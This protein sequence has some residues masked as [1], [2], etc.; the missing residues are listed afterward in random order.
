MERGLPG[1]TVAIGG[2]GWAENSPFGKFTSHR[3]DLSFIALILLKGLKSWE[4][5]RDCFLVSHGL[6]ST[7]G[8]SVGACWLLGQ[9]APNARG[10]Q[11]LC[12][13]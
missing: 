6:E 5:C 12:P 2:P 1:G 11:C 9:L 8:M 4:E 10:Q 13:D 3:K 7:R